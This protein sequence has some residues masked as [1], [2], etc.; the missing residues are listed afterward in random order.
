MLHGTALI[1][2]APSNAAVTG[3]TAF[4]SLFLNGSAI[5]GGTQHGGMLRGASL[6]TTIC[7]PFL[8]RGTPASGSNIYQYRIQVD[9]NNAAGGNETFGTT[10]GLGSSVRMVAQ[11]S[12]V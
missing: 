8:H 6:S 9:L 7:I 4:V 10:G 3:Y 11:E 12:K 5:S 2:I 1:N